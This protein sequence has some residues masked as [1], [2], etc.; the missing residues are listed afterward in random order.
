MDNP[1]VFLLLLMPFLRS[2][3]GTPVTDEQGQKAELFLKPQPCLSDIHAV[4][5]E[6]SAA[7]AEQKVKI[8]QLQAENQAQAA[9][10]REVDTLTQQQQHIQEDLKT[11]ATELQTLKTSS[12]VTESKVESLTQDKTVSQVAFSAAL[13]DSGSQSFGPHDAE[14][15]LVYKH[16]VSNIGNAYSP[17]TGIFT[18]PVRGVYHFEIFALS[19]GNSAVDAYLKKNG[20]GI[21]MAHES[22]SSGHGTGGNAV[23][24][25]L[26]RGDLVYVTLPVNRQLYDNTNHH[27]TFSGHLLFTM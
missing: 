8:E 19:N 4:L 21:F 27:N 20:Q 24:L 1:S 15:T 16:V 13:L 23:T 17:Q 12:T 14:T 3:E 25:L 7:L 18:A 11:Q 2:V 5:R 6:M 10:L 9:K 26:E 22:Q